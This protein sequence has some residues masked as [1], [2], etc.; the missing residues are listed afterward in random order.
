MTLPLQLIASCK[1][2]QDS[3]GFWIP[4][5]SSI[6]DSLSCI[7]PNPKRSIPDF[8]AFRNPD[9]LIWGEIDYDLYWG[10]DDMA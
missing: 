10:G 9:S 8:H 5:V 6:L 1:G 3:L 4:I 2:I 7:P